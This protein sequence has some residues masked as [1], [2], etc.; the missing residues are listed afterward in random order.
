MIWLAH[1]VRRSRVAS[2][3]D[4]APMAAPRTPRAAR[5]APPWR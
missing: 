5:G 2:L 1:Y 3:R 4:R